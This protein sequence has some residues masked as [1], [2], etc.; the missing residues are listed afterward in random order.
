MKTQDL[1]STLATHAAKA[2]QDAEGH[3]DD[4]EVDQHNLYHRGRETAFS[5]IFRLTQTLISFTKEAT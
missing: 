3:I 5:E 1:L 4:R 2:A